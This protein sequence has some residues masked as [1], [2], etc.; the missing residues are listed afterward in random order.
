MAH[1][2]APDTLSID[3]AAWRRALNVRLPATIRIMDCSVAPPGFHARFSASGKTYRY[4]IFHGAVMPPLL[5]GRAWHVRRLGDLEKFRRQ[6]ESFQGWHDFRAFSANRRDGWDESRNTWRLLHEARVEIVP[7]PPEW[8]APGDWVTVVISGN[9]FLYRMV[10]FLVGIS[11]RCAQE[12][13]KRPTFDASWTSRGGKKPL[14]RHARWP[15]AGGGGLRSCQPGCAGQAG[16]GRLK[17]LAGSGSGAYSAPLR[18]QAPCEGGPGSRRMR[19]LGFRLG[20][21]IWQRFPD[22]EI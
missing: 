6:V 18:D 16:G 12:N 11:V 17:N 19:R 20:R 3:A 8:N 22:G 9:G 10:R 5:A 4:Q 2:D 1:F 7:V 21:G 14:V 15:H 13:S